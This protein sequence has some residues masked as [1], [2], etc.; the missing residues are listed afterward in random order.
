MKRIEHEGA[1]TLQPKGILDAILVLCAEAITH[2]MKPRMVSLDKEQLAAWTDWIQKETRDTRCADHIFWGYDQVQKMFFPAL[3]RL[4]HVNEKCI[5]P[6]N[7]QYVGGDV[8]IGCNTTPQRVIA[9]KCDL[10]VTQSRIIHK[11]YEQETSVNDE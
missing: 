11:E 3:L 6:G 9:L 7:P 1:M 4:R 2:G 10:T 8:V 5:V